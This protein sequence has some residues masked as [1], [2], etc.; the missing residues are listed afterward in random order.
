MGTVLGTI[1]VRRRAGVRDFESC[2][3][4]ADIAAFRGKVRIVHDAEV[5]AAYPRCWIGKVTVVTTDGRTLAGR[6]D[7]PKGDPGNSLTRAEIEAKA[8]DLAMFGQAA[9]ESEAHAAVRRLW[10]I[11]EQDRV[12]RL[13]A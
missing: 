11:A 8:V 2:L 1:A 9:S 4:D 7:E 12:D 6:V 10:T 13:L 5:D 3:D